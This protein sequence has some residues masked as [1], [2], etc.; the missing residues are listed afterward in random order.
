MKL[1]VLL[2]ISML[3]LGCDNDLLNKIQMLEKVNATLT[4]INSKIKIENQSL[5]KINSKIKIENQSLKEE[6]EELK[7]RRANLK[8]MF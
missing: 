7:S 5:T 2:I 4:K 3:V 6:V 8:E 1:Y